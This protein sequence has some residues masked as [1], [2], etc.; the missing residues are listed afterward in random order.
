[1]STASAATEQASKMKGVIMTDE[2]T[3]GLNLKKEPSIFEQLY[4][5]GSGKKYV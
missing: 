4:E 1:M 2:T 5:I 3:T